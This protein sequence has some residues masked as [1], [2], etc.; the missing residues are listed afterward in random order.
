MVEVYKGIWFKVG[1]KVLVRPEYYWNVS[2]HPQNLNRHDLDITLEF[3]GEAWVYCTEDEE[4]VDNLFEC[5]IGS[6]AQEMLVDEDR[7]NNL[8]HN[9]EIAFTLSLDQL[10]TPV[11]NYYYDHP[12]TGRLSDHTFLATVWI[13]EPV[14]LLDYVPMN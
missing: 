6:R 3:Y 9:M 5:P 12:F 10:L 14:W 13:E 2:F 1:I 7:Y 4:W 8:L 11:M